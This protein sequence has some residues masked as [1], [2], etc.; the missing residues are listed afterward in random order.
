MNKVKD[1]IIATGTHRKEIMQFVKDNEYKKQV[2]IDVKGIKPDS[3]SIGDALREI[4]E[5]GVLRDDFIVVRGDIITNIKIADA[6]E[7]YWTMK[8]LESKKENQTT[9]TRKNKTILTK[10]FIK[11]SNL[12]PL[13]DPSTD[14]MLMLDNQTQEILKYHSII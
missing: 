7:F 1:I 6:L 11:R 10:L 9:D 13:R 12:N 3:E 2:K 4:S 5:M 8:A 14:I